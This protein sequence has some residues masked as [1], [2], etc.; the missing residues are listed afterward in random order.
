M[1][2]SKMS[3][4]IIGATFAIFATQAAWAFVTG[5]NQVEPIAYNDAAHLMKVSAGSVP[6]VKQVEDAF[7]EQNY[8]QAEAL[9]NQVTEAKPN[10]AKAWYLLA[11]AEEKLGKYGQAKKDLSKAESL[12]A[13]LKFSSP[14]AVPR[15]HQELD[16]LESGRSVAAPAQAMNHSTVAIPGYSQHPAVGGYTSETLSPVKSNEPTSHTW[17][18]VLVFLMAA[19]VGIYWYMNKRAKEKEQEEKERVRKALLSRANALQ[20]RASTLSKTARFEGQE[21]SA[22]GVAA[23]NAVSRANSKLGLLKP[24]NAMFEEEGEKRDLDKLESEIEVLEN[25]SARKQWNVEA[26]Q[27]VASSSLSSENTS[28]EFDSQSGFG[29]SAAGYQTMQQPMFQTAPVVVQQPTTVIVENNN[30]SGLLQTM[31][32][33]DAL[34]ESHHHHQHDYDRDDDRRYSNSSVGYSTRQ[35][36][37]EVEESSSVDLGG[38]SG[39]WDS[40]SS[41]SSSS[42]DD[43]FDSGSSGSSSDDSW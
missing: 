40:S 29:R 2:S 12:D 31:I 4:L 43:S 21:S 11:Q 27:S 9:L 7:R 35:S 37:Q 16:R 38:S 1:K 42:S 41:S 32:L 19:G 3:T 25:Q 20:E 23:A 22:F 8:A 14:G 13:S 10:N 15:M 28:S 24:T 33:A 30:S 26:K 36:S 39:G 6:S 17:I 34:S 18:Y 5:S